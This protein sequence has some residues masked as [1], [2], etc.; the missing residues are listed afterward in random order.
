MIYE[1]CLVYLTSDAI[2]GILIKNIYD[3]THYSRSTLLYNLA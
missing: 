1:A 2:H 3:W